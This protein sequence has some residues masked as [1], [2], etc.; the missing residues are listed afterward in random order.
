[1][2]HVE[3]FEDLRG[4]KACFAKVGSLAG[5]TIP[6]HRLFKSGV[7]DVVDC[8]NHVKSAIEFFGTS[9]AIN[10]LQDRYNPLGETNMVTF[11]ITTQGYKL[12]RL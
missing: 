2:L 9:C 1:M 3:N 4:A 11:F 6:I 12:L 7:M 10:S 5:W 8:N